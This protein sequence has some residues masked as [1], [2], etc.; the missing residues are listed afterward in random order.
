M[1]SELSQPEQG[2]HY[3]ISFVCGIYITELMWTQQICGYQRLVGEMSEG[4]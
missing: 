3:V 1:L 4:G 2:K